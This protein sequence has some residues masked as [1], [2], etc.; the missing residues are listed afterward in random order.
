MSDSFTEG[1]RVY[2][3]EH[4][5]GTYLTGPD[6]LINGIGTSDV[7][8][9]FD[10]VKRTIVDRNELVECHDLLRDVDVERGAEWADEPAGDRPALLAGEVRIDC[11]FATGVAYD[12]DVRDDGT[13]TIQYWYDNGPYGKPPD[14]GDTDTDSP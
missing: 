12:V 10:R 6:G 3:P 11:D 13:L 8:I 4:G 2:H 14:D 9:D 1:D 5:T 7:L